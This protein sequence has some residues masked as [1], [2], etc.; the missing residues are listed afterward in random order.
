MQKNYIMHR[1]TGP[2]LGIMSLS[3]AIFRHDN[4]RPHVTRIVQRVFINP[5]I[6]L[7]PWSAFSPDLSPV[8]NMWHMVAQRLTQIKPPV[9]TPYQ[10]RQ[11]VE[12]AWSDVP[13]KHIQSL[14]NQCQGVWQR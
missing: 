12:A 5:Q 1:H 8:E 14:F 13:Q 3:T 11:R 2:A 6:E 9:A 4:A 10:L 7:H